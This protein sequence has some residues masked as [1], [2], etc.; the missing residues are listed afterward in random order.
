MMCRFAILRCLP[1]LAVLL[2]L[3]VIA[4]TNNLA[5]TPQMGWNDWNSYGCGI[6]ESAVTNSANTIV[7]DGLKAAGYQFVNIDDGWAATRNAY[8]VIQAY[9]IPGKFPDGIAWLANYV[10][11]QGLKLGVYTDHG[12]NTCSS[13]IETSLNPVGEQP[14]SYD[15]EYVDAFTYA[16]WGVDYLKN[17]SCNLPA[18]DV[19]MNDYFRMADGLMKSG[20]P[21]LDS[22]CPNAAHYEYWSPDEGNSWRTTGDIRSTFASM[23]SKID[24]NSRSAYLAGPG[25]W[26]DPDMLEIGNGEFAANYVAAQTHFTMWCV[27]AAP[28]IMGN[29]LSTM[30]AQTLAILTNAEAI[31]VDQDPAGEAGERVGGIVDT[32]EV[33]SKPLGYDFTTRAVALLNRQTNTSAVITCNWTN[34][35]FQPGRTATVRDLWAHENLGTFTNSFTA[36]IPAYGSMLLKIV[37]TP[38]PPPPPG[39]NYLTTLQPVYAY[40]GWGTMVNNQSIGGNPLTLNGVV[41]T[42]GI[43]THAIGGNEY[44][45][46]GVGSHFHAVVGVDDEVGANNGSVIFQVIADGRRIYESGIMTG[47]APAQ[48]IDLDLTGVRR[49]VLGVTDTGNDLDANRNDDDHSDWADALVIV[50][51]STPQAPE[52]PTGLAAIPGNAITLTWSNTL[53]ALTYN[54]KRSTVSG[55]GYT[56]IANVPVT[57]F[58]DTNVVN[59]T[60]YYYVVSAVS[61]FGEGSNSLA[62]AATPCSS[63]A[64]PAGVTA[65]GSNVQVVV[66]WNASAGATGYNVSR[67]TGNTPPVVLA[68]GLTATNFTDINLVSGTIYYYLVAATNA[69]S[70]SAFAT[71]VPAIVA[72]VAPT[73]LTAAAGDDDVV[74]NWNVT[75]GASGYNI[76]RST[77]NGGPY[78]VI[79]SNLTVASYADFYVLDGTKYYYVVSALNAGG[80]SANSAPASATPATPRTA[81]WTNTVTSAPQNWNVNAN[82]TNVATFPNS[83][84]E[85]TVI[86]ANLSAPQTINLNQAITIGSLQIG[87][88]NGAASYTLAANGGSLTFSDTNTVVLTQSPFQQ[89]RRDRRAGHAQHQF[90][91]HQRFDESADTGGHTLQFRRRLDAGQRRACRWRRHHE[92]QPRLRQRG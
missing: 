41:Y 85:L 27:M 52:M 84:G 10:H 6:S 66:S 40:S 67:F 60:A 30:S 44:I 61:S 28:L 77:T 43:G 14:G 90:D 47:G 86:K 56:N 83:S 63:P 72:P 87:A 50:T 55:S 17:D 53:A 62:V 1:L 18:N 22:L 57:T 7:A 34:L 70:Q 26:N 49:L 15:Y 82:W 23:I 51:N 54:V 36:T 81:C 89:R 39:T 21:I 80:E 45:L 16:S 75:A 24:Q 73:G 79:S 13:C 12:T 71:F 65:A 68:T 48:T 8:G 46:G 3:Q 5:L 25:R 11:A 69:C 59:G 88:A 9:S 91:R 76:K 19:P 37:G 35:A 92:R 33:W 32:A 4:L 64:V 20:Q 78:L 38:I 74:L 2:P 58:T 42:N 29:V 31:A